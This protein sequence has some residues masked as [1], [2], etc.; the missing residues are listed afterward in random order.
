MFFIHNR[1]QEFVH[2]H[3]SKRHD[4]NDENIVF[5][6]SKR[7]FKNQ[8]VF[9]ESK[10]YSK[11]SLYHGINGICVKQCSPEIP[12][13]IFSTNPRNR[14]GN[15][16][17]T[18]TSQYIHVIFEEELYIICQNK[19]LIWPEMYKRLIDDGFGVI[20]SNKKEISKRVCEFNNLREN[21]FIDN[22]IFGNKVVFMDVYIFRTK[23]L[24]HDILLKIISRV[25][26]KDT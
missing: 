15:K 19:N 1:F 24:T 12:R 18:H 8:S 23:A 9:Q 10:R 25:S 22:G 5:Q 13:G 2:Q 21:I 26:L 4:K 17:N 7:F 11:R 16:F 14:N 3:L 6:I 20:K